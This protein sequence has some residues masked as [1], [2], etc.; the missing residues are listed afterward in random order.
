MTD[1]QVTLKEVQLR[2]GAAQH[3]L[4]HLCEKGVIEPDFSAT[5]GRGKRREFSE[6][7]VFEF[8]VALAVRKLEL[9]V[10]SAALV[11]RLLRAFGRAVNKAVPGFELPISLQ[12]G[13]IDLSLFLCDGETV[14]LCA[15]GK[16][17]KAP[18]RLKAK[19]PEHDE[20]TP[21]IQKLESL[22][23]D[24]E[25]RLEINLTAIAQRIAK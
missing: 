8:A 16:S 14:M 5:T 6:R 15:T 20:S 4:I 7:N 9:P 10:S 2:L 3:V 19:L 23:G 22:Q 12:S 13:E 1:Q 24:Y 18:V 17:F 21:Q 25:V 11:V